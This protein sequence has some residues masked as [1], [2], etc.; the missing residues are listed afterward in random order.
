MEQWKLAKTYFEKSM[1]EH[2]TPEIKTQLSEVEKKIAEEEKKAYVDP[3]KAEQEKELGNEYFK[4]G[5]NY[6]MYLVLAS[7]CKSKGA[8]TCSLALS[9]I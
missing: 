8:I 6:V 7:H 2:R 9:D 5:K 1:S 3:V 4:K